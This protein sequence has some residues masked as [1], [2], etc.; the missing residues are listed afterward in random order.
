[1]TITIGNTT[2]NH[3]TYDER[4]DVLYPHVGD[5]QPAAGTLGT[6]EGHA[7][8]CDAGGKAIG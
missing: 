1:M 8:R 2:F 3:V 7:V 4:G 6:P 5:R